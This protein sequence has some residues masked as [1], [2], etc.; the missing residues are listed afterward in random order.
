MAREWREGMSGIEAGRVKKAYLKLLL[1]FE[2]HIS[3]GTT[4]EVRKVRTP[5]LSPPPP[6]THL[7]P[8][9]PT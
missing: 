5:T 1:A 8:H 4:V 9:N 2:R 7:L 3:Q 6:H